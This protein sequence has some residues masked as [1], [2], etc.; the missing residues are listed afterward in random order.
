MTDRGR[1]SA[2][3]KERAAGHEN[4]RARRA[5]RRRRQD[6]V[7]VMTEGWYVQVTCKSKRIASLIGD[8]DVVQIKLYDAVAVRLGVRPIIC[9]A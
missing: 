9:M 3:G 4:A 8:L 6:S 7:G 1:W 2:A 5:R